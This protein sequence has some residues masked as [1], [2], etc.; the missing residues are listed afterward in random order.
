MTSFGFSYKGLVK[1]TS[2]TVIDMRVDCQVLGAISCKELTYWER[3]WCWEGLGAGGEGDDRGWDGWM[4]T[5]TRWTWVWV[6]SRSWWWT[7]RPGV[8]WFMGLQR[9][10]HDRA[11]ELS[12][13]WGLPRWLSGKES[14]CQCRRCEFNPWVGKIPWRRKWHDPLQYFCLENPMDSG[15]C[16]AAV[17]GISK[18]QTWLSH[19]AHILC[20]LWKCGKIAVL[21]RWVF[22]LVKLDV[23]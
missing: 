6:N 13:L 5:P 17:H 12:V 9:V 18:S 11:T 4:A 1:L 23:P 22:W 15:A 3:P 8:L 20:P 21:R 14:A 16:P 7:G 2:E 19:W 10:G